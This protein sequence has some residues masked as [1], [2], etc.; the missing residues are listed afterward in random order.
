MRGP[1]SRPP[2]RQ[3]RQA[4]LA[5]EDA[6]AELKKLVPEDAKYATGHGVKAKRSKSGVISFE[7][8][9]GEAGDAPRQ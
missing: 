5:H 7:L 1:R 2:I 4:H 9:E 8:A 6:E 3:T